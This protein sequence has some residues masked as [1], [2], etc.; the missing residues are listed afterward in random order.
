[1]TQHSARILAKLAAGAD[2]LATA[3]QKR[4]NIAEDQSSLCAG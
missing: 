2:G 4:I 1:M 3:G